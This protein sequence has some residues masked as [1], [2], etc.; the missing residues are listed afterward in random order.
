[1]SSIQTGQCLS[2]SEKPYYRA[3]SREIARGMSVPLVSHAW[4]QSTEGD[5]LDFTDLAEEAEGSLSP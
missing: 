2:S 4:P 5:F 1:M 3:L